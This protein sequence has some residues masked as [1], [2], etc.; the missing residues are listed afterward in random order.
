VAADLSDVDGPKW[1]NA[2]WYDAIKQAEQGEVDI[3]PPRKWLKTP[4]RLQ[5][6]ISMASRYN[7]YK[8]K[9]PGLRLFAFVHTRPPP[10]PEYISRI[11]LA[12]LWKNSS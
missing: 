9:F 10:L 8:K 7:D 1:I 2:L 5:L 6:T 11:F 12:R 4:A 3:V